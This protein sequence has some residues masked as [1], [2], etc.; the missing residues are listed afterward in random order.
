MKVRKTVLVLATAIAVVGVYGVQSYAQNDTMTAPVKMS[1]EE[2]R[3]HYQ[4]IQV[5]GGA[6]GEFER[7]N[8]PIQA[9]ESVIARDTSK[10]TDHTEFLVT[11]YGVFKRKTAR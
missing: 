8:E 11:E 4:E 1:E 5:I 3:Q 9:P 10:I 6:F 7:T 2:I